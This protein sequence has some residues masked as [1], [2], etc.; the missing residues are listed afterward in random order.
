MNR[1]FLFAASL[2]CSC[3][4]LIHFSSPLQAEPFETILFKD[5]FSGSKLKKE[6]GSWKSESVVR[7][8]VLVG[9]TPTDADHPSVNTIKLPPVS[10]LEVSVSF[11]FAGSK[12][13]NV[14]FRDL[15]YKGS[16]AGHICHVGVTANA[17]MLYDG[18][19]GQFRKDIRDK[20]K[21]GIKLDAETREMLKT[22]MSTNKIALDPEEWHDLVIRIEGDMIKAWIDGEQVGELKSE[23][24]AHSSKSNMNI[25]TVDREVHYDNFAIKTR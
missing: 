8:G 13:F 20:R 2:A 14:M 12:R 22:K 16:H 17:I 25:T 19:T 11:K 6:W 15:D 23:G 4:L 9:I 10:D 7:D 21:A 18:K 24:I 3:T 5:D 1:Y